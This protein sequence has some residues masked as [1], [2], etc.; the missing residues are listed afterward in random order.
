MAHIN[1][2]EELNAHTIPALKAMCAERG[3]FV[4]GRKENLVNRILV[5]E[6]HARP[7]GDLRFM[8]KAE[9]A[10]L[11]DETIL[12]AL[13]TLGD[14]QLS[15]VPHKRKT[16]EFM[17]RACQV[18]VKAL[19]HSPKWGGDAAFVSKSIDGGLPG[20]F[21]YSSLVNRADRDLAAKAIAKESTMFLSA[22][23][24][25]RND[26]EFVIPLLALK[27]P[28]NAELAHGDLFLYA[29]PEVQ[30]KPKAVVFAAQNCSSNKAYRVMMS[31]PVEARMSATI[32]GQLIKKDPQVMVGAP[33]NLKES[34]PFAKKAARMN[35]KVL[36]YLDKRWQNTAGVFLAAL[37][38]CP[39]AVLHTPHLIDPYIDHY[40]RVERNYVASKEEVY[41]FLCILKRPTSEGVLA[42]IARLS[43]QTR[44]KFTV[45]SFLMQCSSHPIQ[46]AVTTT[47]RA[48]L[49]ATIEQ[50]GRAAKIQ[51]AARG[52]AL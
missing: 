34:L 48:Q 5:H 8:S 28:E 50:L 14:G 25:L 51:K 49:R 18:D 17:T 21:Q 45:A 31:M 47:A 33:P 42:P 1:R 24:T 41:A 10:A 11:T 20:V 16:E 32:M 35:G 4:G 30:R 26:P 36:P 15:A 3:L 9:V 2:T 6:G 27:G 19:K 39:K 37:V 23:S 13:Q 44:V 43:G 38:Q 40:T 52:L 46:N 29:G 7:E 22:A 12:A